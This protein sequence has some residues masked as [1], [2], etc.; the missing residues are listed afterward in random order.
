VILSGQIVVSRGAMVAR[1]WVQQATRYVVDWYLG[2]Y[3]LGVFT[4]NGKATRKLVLFVGHNR[5]LLFAL[6]G[7]LERSSCV[8]IHL[9][10]LFDHVGRHFF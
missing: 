8:H 7:K 4:T 9:G 3:I 6:F 1:V 10:Q 5:R 2:L